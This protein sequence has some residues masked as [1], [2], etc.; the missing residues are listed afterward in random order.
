M[1]NQRR[2]N[3]LKYVDQGSLSFFFSGVEI[4]RSQDANYPFSVDRNFYY[5]TGIN[6]SN[7]VLLS[8][9][10]E[11]QVESFLFIEPFDPIKALWDGAGLSFEEAAQLSQIPLKNVRD[12]QSLDQF[13]AN[14]LSTSRRAIFGDIKT[15]Y[16]DLDRLKPDLPDRLSQTYA[17][18]LA[19]L[20]PYISIKPNQSYLARL[21]TVK[22]DEEIARIKAGIKITQEGLHTIMDVIKPGLK[23]YE[24]EASFNYVLN[25][26]RAIPGFTSICASGKNAT[27]LHYIDNH[28]T[29]NDGEL[30]LFDLGACKDLYSADISRTYP[31]N[32]KFSARQ[33]AVYEVVLEANKKTIEWLKPGI[34]MA[35]FNQYGKNILIEGAKKLGLIEKDEEILKYYYHSLGHYLGLD[36]HDVGRYSEPIPV[37]AII[38]VEPGLYIAEEGIGIRIED[39]VLV[40]EDG[41]VNLSRDIIKEV[42]DIEAY[43]AKR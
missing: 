43:M 33:R 10:G 5:L 29:M 17:K 24:V 19:S 38:T 28:D 2:N 12:I 21:R 27:V 7:V 37:G 40:T 8:I 13:V 26:H 31:V 34:T 9:K 16:L 22:N 11:S 18:K 6:Q 15:A 39:D 42:D 25:K 36:I 23:E 20:F 4:Q 14:L 30:M 32:G 41:C 3:Y 35:E 1:F